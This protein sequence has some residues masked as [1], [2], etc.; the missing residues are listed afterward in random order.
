MDARNFFQP[1]RSVLKRTNSVARLE[2]PSSATS[3]SGLAI[4]RARSA[5]RKRIQH[6]GAVCGDAQR[7]FFRI[8]ADHGPSTGNPF[9]NNIIPANRINQT[10]NYFIPLFPL[11]NSGTQYIYSPPST[12]NLNQETGRVDYYI[13]DSNRLFGSYTASGRNVFDPDPQPNN[14]GL[15]RQGLAQRANINWNKTITPTM[16]NTLML[17]WSRFKN[18]LTPS[19]LGTNHT[20]ESGLQGFEQTSSRF[21]VSQHQYRRL[22]R[23][24]RVR[25]GPAD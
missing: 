19:I 2:V 25:L 22:S 4:T 7:R 11:P 3:C 10:A 9:P 12:V 6:H 1:E 17:G 16:M 13:N 15:T 24:R 21:P 8:A 23:H 20:V 18:V 14:G 5:Q